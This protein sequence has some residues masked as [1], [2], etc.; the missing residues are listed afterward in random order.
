[1][2]PWFFY[3]SLDGRL[4]SAIYLRSWF[5]WLSIA[6]WHYWFA[7]LQLSWQHKYIII[8]VRTFES[9]L[10]RVP[11]ESN[12]YMHTD[13]RLCP[14]SP[15][16]IETQSDDRHLNRRNELELPNFGTLTI[17]VYLN[18][19]NGTVNLEVNPPNLAEW[20][21]KPRIEISNLYQ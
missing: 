3:Q 10:M 8:T 5:I 6:R 11:Q 17:T 18:R 14:Y 4:S 21:L 19:R 1:M 13:K 2:T 15:L 12:N 20:N 7:T 9:T 16:P